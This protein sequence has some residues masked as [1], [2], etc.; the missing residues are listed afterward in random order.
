M[1]MRA[2]LVSLARIKEGIAAY[3]SQGTHRTGSPEADKTVDWLMAEIKK[4]GLDSR[5]QSLSFNRPDIKKAYV[6]IN[7]DRVSGIPLFD[8]DNRFCQSITGK[9]GAVEAE[10]PIVVLQEN[11]DD[12]AATIAANDRYLASPDI[13]AMIT[14]IRHKQEG[15]FLI[16]AENFT[17]PSGFPVLQLSSQ[18]WDWLAE[19]SRSGEIGRICI[20]LDHR[21]QKIHNILVTVAGLQQELAP[22][23]VTTPYNGWWHSTAERAGGIVACLEVMRILSKNP[24]R[25]NLVFL[26]TTGH[27]LGHLG[28]KHF[29]S[30]SRAFTDRSHAWIHLGANLAS[31]EIKCLRLQASDQTYQNLGLAALKTANIV[32]EVVRSGHEEVYGEVIDLFNSGARGVSFLGKNDYFHL[33]QDRWPESVDP[34]V[35]YELT[36]ALLEL[37]RQMGLEP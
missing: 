2:N 37:C 3:D 24:I 33:P 34:K 32:P 5:L 9:L 16:N 14:T 25:R 7:G 20:D 28:I 13:R 15:H 29:L 4:A 6:E 22:I 8:R 1:I 21:P 30:E 31:P 18:H 35:V 23:A 26:F 17:N 27:E 11:F 12:L 19:T 10:T 36:R